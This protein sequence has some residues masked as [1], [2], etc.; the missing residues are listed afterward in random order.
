[1][2]PVAYKMS[3]KKDTILCMWS[4]FRWMWGKFS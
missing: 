2:F 1:M 4:G 3:H